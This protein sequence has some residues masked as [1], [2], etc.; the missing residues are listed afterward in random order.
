MV[1]VIPE[2][3]EAESITGWLV[4]EDDVVVLVMPQDIQAPKGRLILPQVPDHPGPFG[5]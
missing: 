2:D 4:N 1:R 3:F 5:P